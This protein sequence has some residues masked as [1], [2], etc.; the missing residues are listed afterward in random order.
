M[1]FGKNKRQNAIKN[2]FILNESIVSL[3]VGSWKINQLFFHTLLRFWLEFRQIQNIQSKYS[4]T[5]L[6][7]FWTPAYY[8]CIYVLLIY[9]KMA[10]NYWVFVVHT[11]TT[12]DQQ[13]HNEG[14]ICC[15]LLRL[16]LITAFY[17]ANH[18]PYS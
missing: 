15:F 2:P 7:I 6:S 16:T 13:N 5:C 9:I 11:T 14:N 10:L 12:R 4:Y 3:E 18:A 1:F 17:L 8:C